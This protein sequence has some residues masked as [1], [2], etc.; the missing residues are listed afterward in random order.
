MRWRVEQLNALRRMLDEKEGEIL[1]AL[2]LDLG[3][4][5][6]EAWVSEIGFLK[7]EIGYTTKHLADWMQPQR[8]GAP[9]IQQPARATIV[10]EPLGVVLIIGPWNYPLQLVLAPLIGAIAA[11]NCSLIKPSELAANTSALLARLIPVYL[12]RHAVEVVE[13]AVEETTALLK[14]RFDHIFFTGGATVGRIVMRAASEYLTPVTLELGGKS[15]CIVDEKVD[16]AVAAKRII[17]GKFLNA[18]QTCVAP[19]YLLVH[20][21]V[22]E[23]L[24]RAMKSALTD[25]Y[26][27]DPRNS[28]DYGRIISRRH[29]D[30]LVSLMD[31][32]DVEVG[33]E[34]DEESR[35]LAPTIISRPPSDSPLMSEEIFGPLLPFVVVDSIGEAIDQI[36][37]R[38]RPLAL[39]LFSKDKAV[40]E[41]V[42]AETSSGGVCINDVVVHLLPHELPFGGVGESGMGAYHGRASFECFSHSKSL[43][44]RS[45]KI[46]P[47]RRY[48]PYNRRHLN[49]IKRLFS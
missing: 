18:G 1:E 3:K 39:Y 20:R 38:P 27:D 2:A 36:N 31:G 19:D 49:I 32:M 7:Q 34:K 33:G 5:V 37:A 6:F 45:T 40:H 47:R 9:I 15:P 42:V 10:R 48:P 4:S 23:P 44:N 24:M 13:G 11:G 43:L 17:W 46:D 12:D 14:E 29:F 30:R 35:Y 26:G 41:T 25:F 28:P 16:L 21:A 8:V 22:A